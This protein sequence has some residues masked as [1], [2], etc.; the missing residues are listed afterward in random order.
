MPRN[1]TAVRVLI[2]SPSDT[3][4]ERETLVSVIGRWNAAKAS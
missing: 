1:A 4:H 2:A 3:E